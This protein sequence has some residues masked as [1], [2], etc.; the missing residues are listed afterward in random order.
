MKNFLAGLVVA[1]TFM[2]WCRPAMAIINV[3]DHS[4]FNQYIA[5]QNQTGQPMTFV[6]SAMVCVS[7]SPDSFTVGAN[8]TVT[9]TVTQK[10]YDTGLDNCYATHHNITY[11]DSANSNSMFRIQQ[12][13]NSDQYA[14][15]DI[16]YNIIFWIN[17]AICPEATG[18]VFGPTN[19]DQ[20]LVVNCA[21]GIPNCPPSDNG[22][23]AEY[24]GF[25]IMNPP[26]FTVTLNN[27]N[28]GQGVDCIFTDLNNKT[29]RNSCVVAYPSVNPGSKSAISLGGTCGNK[30]YRLSI[31][32]NVQL[33]CYLSNTVYQGVK[34]WVPTTNGATYVYPAASSRGWPH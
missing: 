2:A 32:T 9:I 16:K 6:R 5:I 21:G 8:S 23:T 3:L 19:S 12:Y 20:Y 34:T 14:C 28:Q 15:L 17:Q 30:F 1:L 4:S 33:L 10:Y 29:D 22:S 24:F 27:Q 13:N 18:E 11:Q 25:L 26:P 31:R 7:A